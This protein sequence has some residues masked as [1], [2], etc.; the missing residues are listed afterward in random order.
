MTPDMV[1]KARAN[2]V[3]GG[4]TNVE[5]RLGEIEH[6][7]VGDNSVDAVLSNCV[8]NLSPEK[9]KVYAEAFRVLKPGGRLAISDVVLT[10]ELPDEIRNDPKLLAGCV[11][12]AATIDELESILRDSGFTGVSIQAKDQSRKFIRQWTADKNVD[13]Y[14]VSASIEAIKPPL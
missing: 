6:L 2:A 5:F 11:S 7:P 10:A 12:G 4:Y 9:R 1:S 3:T 13:E 8:I 14:V